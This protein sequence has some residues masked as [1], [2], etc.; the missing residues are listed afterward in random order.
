LSLVQTLV[1]LVVIAENLQVYTTD[2]SLPNHTIYKPRN[3]DS[4]SGTLPVVTWGNGGCSGNG[5]D[6]QNFN[7]EIA[8]HGFVVIASGGPGGQGSTTAQMMKDSIDW[9]SRTAGSGSWAKMN[10]KKV[11]LHR[12]N[13]YSSDSG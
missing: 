4:V 2:P 9:A 7:L 12:C 8:S 6:Q 10:A 3:M 11:R 1:I 5:L 13:I